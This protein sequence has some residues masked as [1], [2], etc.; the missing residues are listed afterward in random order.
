MTFKKQWRIKNYYFFKTKKEYFI[1]S[2]EPF[3]YYRSISEVIKKTNINN[4]LIYKN[5]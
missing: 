2:T 1:T 5:K 4:L 3:I